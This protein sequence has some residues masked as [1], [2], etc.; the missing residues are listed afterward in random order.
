MRVAVREYP[1]L[2]NMFE[3]LLKYYLARD[4]TA[5]QELSDRELE[6]SDDDLVALVNDVLITKRNHN[7]LQNMQPHL[8]KGNAFIAV[9]ALHLPGD[10]GL[11]RL[12]EQR[13]YRVRP[14]Y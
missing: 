7:M 2:D 13:G 6:G 1:K 8:K 14:V 5:L 10:T 4:L 12:L 3:T 9:G 11:L